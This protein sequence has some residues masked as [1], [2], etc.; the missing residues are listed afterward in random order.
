MTTRPTLRLPCVSDFV[1]S[2]PVE[3]RGWVV[4]RLPGKKSLLDRPIAAGDNGEHSQLHC[5]CRPG[6]YSGVGRREFEVA[7]GTIF[8]VDKRG[9][10]GATG[11]AWSALAPLRRRLQQFSPTQHTIKITLL[12]SLLA[13]AQIPESNSQKFTR[14]LDPTNTGLNEREMHERT[15]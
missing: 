5:G 7:V 10:I 8:A 13:S 1:A 3:L 14:N 12:S 9:A 4:W 11:L 15:Q 2:W 6:G